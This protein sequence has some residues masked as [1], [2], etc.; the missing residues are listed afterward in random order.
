[1]C[2]NIRALN[3]FAPPATSEE[4]HAAA[5]QFIRK[6]GGGKPSR[7]NTAAFESAVAQVAAATQE[8]LDGLVTNAPPKDRETE[9]AKARARVRA[10]YPG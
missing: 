4:V 10:H 8:F 6:V 9:A 5:I 3:N 2:R 1:M 7:A